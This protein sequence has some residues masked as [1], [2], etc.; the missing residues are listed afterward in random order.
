MTFD[1]VNAAFWG[2]LVLV[3]LVLLIPLHWDPAIR[4]RER[5][6]D[7]TKRAP[8]PKPQIPPMSRGV[9]KLVNEKK[10]PCDWCVH[11]DCNTGLTY[12]NAECT[13]CTKQYSNWVLSPDKVWPEE[14]GRRP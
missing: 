9:S 8:A 2:L 10:D 7:G 4:L 5:L 11:L 6:E 12:Q 3:L 14:W 13:W 1:D